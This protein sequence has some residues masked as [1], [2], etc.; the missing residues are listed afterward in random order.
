MQRPPNLLQDFNQQ[1]GVGGGIG[2]LDVTLDDGDPMENLVDGAKITEE[3]DGSIAIDLEPEKP[4]DAA[5][6]PKVNFNANLALVLESDSDT[7]AAELCDA[8]EEDDESRSEWKSALVEGMKLMGT[9]IEKRSRPFPG[10][11]GVWDPMMAEA[12]IRFWALFHAE[13]LPARGP[14]KAMINGL[15]DPATL[16]EASRVQMFMNWYLTAVAKEYYPGMDQ[17]GFWLALAGSMF[18]K[19]YQDPIKGR[20]VSPLIMPED[21]IVP[22]TATSIEDATR[23]TI[24]AHMP[25]RDIKLRMMRDIWR[26]FALGE[27]EVPS[28]GQRQVKDAVDRAE[29]RKPMGQ[30]RG[31]QVYDIYETDVDLDLSN[32]TRGAGLDAAYRGLPLPYRVVIDK[33]T[34]KCLSLKRN[35]KK[36]DESFTK[37]QNVVHY[38][39]LP[40]FSF[41]GFGYAHVLGSQATQGTSLRR[42]IIDAQ[43]LHMFPGGL[44][45]KGMRFDNNNRNIGPTEFLEVDTGGLPLNQAVMMTPYKEL[46]QVPLLTLKD[47]TEGAKSLASNVDIAVGE[48]RQDAPVGTTLA[49]IEGASRIVS[50][51]LKL[52]HTSFREELGLI[53]DTFGEFMKEGGPYPF[54]VAGGNAIIAKNDFRDRDRVVPVSDPDCITSTQRIMRAEAD[55]RLAMQAPNIHN[56]REAYVG[57]YQAMG[58]SQDQIDRILPP[59]QQ[60]QPADPLTEN[61][62]AI[63]GGPLK[64]GEAQD[65]DAHIM[66]HQ[67]LMEIPQMQ[68]HIA[69]H[70]ALKMRVDV[71][72]V[73]G[74]TLP[75]AGTPLPPEIENQ[76]AVLVAKA[77]H[78][79]EQE[80]GQSITQDQIIQAQLQLEATD[81]ANKLRVD[82]AKI[83]VKAY[84]IKTKANTAT[85]DREARERDSLLDAAANTADNKVPA[86]EYVQSILDM[87]RDKGLGEK[88]KK[89]SPGKAAQAAD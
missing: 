86:V 2:D 15:D 23:L 37:K 30:W 56:L 67:P 35:W 52:F 6:D 8:I 33:T 75:P 83:Q 12:V 84:E 81:I 41:Y 60:T 5:L 19:V 85:L 65:H 4:T 76:I 20:P 22:Y 34:M 36:G 16:D 61:Q 71:Q 63:T 69:E 54:P 40:G 29:G 32:F 47:N 44:R 89:A 39:F 59:P 21:C 88:E 68:A 58:K 50:S 70:M 9:K 31:D 80:K 11:S 17:L 73:L 10:A 28:S 57:M 38:K 24:V 48:G 77:M 46:S 66:A 74:I 1:P 49:L 87:G 42:Q 26:T 79:L 18:K 64:A 82:M 45:V 27:P 25:V 55:L 13:I 43:T 53:H 14:V 7:I 78:V 51:T 72:R 3:G 62:T